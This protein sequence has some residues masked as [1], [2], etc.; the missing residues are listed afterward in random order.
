M[1]NIFKK[2]LEANRIT[3]IK[4]GEKTIIAC[5]CVP[6]EIHQMSSEAT[7][8]EIEDGS[9]ISD[10]VIKRGK[11][12]TI[13]GIVSDDP[14][15]ILQSGFLDRI[16]SALTPTVLKSKSS[17]GLSGDK[18]KP[19][20]EAFDKLEEIYDR[21]I[22]VTII[23]GL[24]KYDNMIMEDVTIPRD[25]KTVRSLKFT[26]TFRQVVIVSTI[27]TA[28]PAVFQDVELG[29]QPKKNIGKQGTGTVLPAP[30]NR[31][32]SAWFGDGLVNKITG[33]LQ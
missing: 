23:T 18:G 15:N 28:A 25:S 16:V 26:A 6:S 1:S 4:D 32:V 17:Y 11:T 3:L 20:K 7:Q 9:D 2:Y 14:I 21:K 22:P 12:L 30:D 31:T 24:K 13:D 29:A 8:F 33:V 19:S 10:H 5:D 27:L